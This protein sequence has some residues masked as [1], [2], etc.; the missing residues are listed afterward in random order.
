M[1]KKKITSKAY[2]RSSESAYARERC[3]FISVLAKLNLIT[4]TRFTKDDQL[5]GKM[6]W[7]LVLE[8]KISDEHDYKFRG[9][10]YDEVL[11]DPTK[12]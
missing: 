9:E 7:C 8:S 2:V 1:K 10:R 3:D 6:R 12:T 5:D 11:R 4:S